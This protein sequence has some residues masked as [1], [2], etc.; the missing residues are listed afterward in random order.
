MLT[1]VV[2]SRTL[3]PSVVH[4]RRKRASF[5]SVGV[6]VVPFTFVLVAFSE[7]NAGRSGLETTHACMPEVTHPSMALFPVSTVLGFVT[8]TMEGFA[9]CTLHSLVVVF[10]W[11]EHVSAYVARLLAP[12]GAATLT[13]V[14]PDGAPF[15]SKPEPTLVPIEHEYDMATLMPTSAIC[16]WQDNCATISSVPPTHCQ[17]PTHTPLYVGRHEPP[18]QRAGSGCD[19]GGGHC[20][21]CCTH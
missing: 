1:V 5:V 6:K 13:L 18:A 19:G 3:P 14:A 7:V 4:R 17:F 15:V 21:P 10:P 9:T 16:G 11:Y 2:A 20:C 8:R 12:G